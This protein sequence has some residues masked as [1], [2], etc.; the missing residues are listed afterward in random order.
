MTS[1]GNT[2]CWGTAGGDAGR[3][4]LSWRRAKPCRRCG[5]LGTHYLTCPLLQVP[6]DGELPGEGEPPR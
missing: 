3:P 6:V 4:G 2:P 1:D 5:G